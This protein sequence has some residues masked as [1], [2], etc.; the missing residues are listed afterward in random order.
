MARVA[1]SFGRLGYGG[2]DSFLQLMLQICD[3]GHHV[4]MFG[5]KQ[6]SAQVQA[7]HLL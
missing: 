7:L 6:S 2:V 3:G 4:T 5:E 1:L